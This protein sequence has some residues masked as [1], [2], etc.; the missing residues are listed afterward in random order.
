MARYVWKDGAWRDRATDEPM[1]VPERTGICMPTM[2]SDIEDYKSPIDGK[3][4]T[5][6]SQQRY[7]LEKND[8][9]LSEKPRQKFDP[10]EYKWRKG[11]QAKQ[12]AKRQAL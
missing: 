11:E 1:P 4:I 9:V 2:R 7:D 6:R 10:E 5:S 12:L 8:C 3:P